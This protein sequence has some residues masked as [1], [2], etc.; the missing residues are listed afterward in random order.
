MYKPS[1]IFA[2]FL[3]SFAQIGLPDET[4]SIYAAGSS[5]SCDAEAMCMNCMVKVRLLR[6][7]GPWARTVGYAEGCRCQSV[8]RGRVGNVVASGR[9]PSPPEQKWSKHLP[10]RVVSQLVVRVTKALALQ[11]ERCAGSLLAC[12]STTIEFLL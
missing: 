3:P 11:R 4:C 1:F 5:E 9:V 7:I 8:A 2:C 6:V 10:C 12:H